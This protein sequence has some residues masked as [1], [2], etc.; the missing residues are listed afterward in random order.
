VVLLFGE[1]RLRGHANYTRVSQGARRVAVDY[2]LGRATVPVLLGLA[3]VVAVSDG[4]PI[5]TLVKWLTQSSH[6]ALSSAEGNLRDVLPATLTSVELGVAA[7]LVALVLAVPVA[8]TAVRH[9]SPL[10]TALERAT[11]LSFALPDLVAA[12]ALAY[13]ASHYVR[14]LYGSF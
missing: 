9:R 14:F 2:E 5:G 10:V 3:G 12:V 8:V 6:A 1:A 11:S 13:A 7:A 4:I